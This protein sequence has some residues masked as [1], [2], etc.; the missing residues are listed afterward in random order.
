MLHAFRYALRQLRNSPGFAATAILTL[1]LGIGATT[2]I[3]SILDAVLLQP[4]PFP[5]PDRLVALNGAHGDGLSIPTIRDW[6]QR[7]RSFQSI[8]GY[9]GAVPTVRSTRGSEAGQVIEVT[10]NF[11]STI[12]IP[13][14]MGRDFPQTGNESDCYS[15]AI[16]SGAFWKRLGGGSSFANRTIE[17]DRHSY[18]IVGVLPLAQEMEGPDAF[19][20]PEVLLPVGCDPFERPNARGDFD[21]SAIGRLRS[22]IKPMQAEHE[23]EAI[24]RPLTK[25]FP[26]HYA[27]SFAP[28]LLP[29]ADLV[30]G[31][32]TRAALLT[33]LSA[34]GLLLL[35]AC[36][37]LA[38]LLLARN[39]R[40]HH[41]FATRATLGASLSQLISQLL[42]ESAVL[43]ALGA[44][45]GL[46][47]AEAAIRGV[48]QL[49]VLHMP[50]IGHAA[51]YPRVLAFA[52][53]VSA[54]VTI[55]LTLL[56]ALRTLRP[57]LLT[58]LTQSGRGT[59]SGSSLRRAGRVLVAAQIAIGLVL[60]SWAGWTISS[61]Y[62]LIHQPLGFAPDH[63]LLAGVDI[64]GSSITPGYDAPRTAL[65]FTEAMETLRRLPGVDAVAAANHPPISGSIDRT[66]FCSDAHPDQC[67]QYNEHGPDNFHV[68]PGYF[69]AIGQTLYSGRDFNA[70]DKGGDHVAIVN[71]ALATQE[72]H[73]QDPI[74]KRIWSG[75]I[76][77]WATVIGVVGNVHNFDLT[78]PP[79]P[80]LYFPEADHPK[81][82]L[83]IVLRTNGDP[84]GLAETVRRTLVRE[85]PDLALFR[86]QPMN[87]RM[88]HQVAQRSFLMQVASAFGALALFLAILGTYGLLAYEVSLRQ[89]EIGI[90]L[91]LGSSR[92]AIVQL[93]LGQESRWVLIGAGVGLIAATLTGYALRAQFYRA[94]AASLPV[95]ATSLALLII[96]SLVAIVLPARRAAH[97]DP[98]ET[99]RSE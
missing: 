85:H 37:N 23:L 18:R 49:T 70:E 78:S 39:T 77:A 83:T 32:G 48:K 61:V 29:L 44:C 99:L 80:N 63:L 30:A 12:G 17:I 16:V 53:L 74:G 24:Q 36:A 10:Q 65:F 2:A 71:R 62:T 93:L 43:A 68:T 33:T 9:K 51:M 79:V 55:L 60:V 40:R 81:T 91:A 59:S 84:A 69:S 27:V 72:W 4:L 56:P 54:A 67:H 11:L 64:H 82:A 45:A 28:I 22:G 42:V 38:N 31:T 87:A 35:I 34:C 75:D 21:F 97:L 66:G 96:P 73:E 58:D 26:R 94:G 89:R 76:Q 95:L 57:S 86:L 19:N 3:F 5:Q 7:S 88:A 6:Q 8:A 47:L 20:H 14:A 50:R 90:R 41:E 25:A 1:A 98:V 15:E 46:V 52:I 13:L 92:E